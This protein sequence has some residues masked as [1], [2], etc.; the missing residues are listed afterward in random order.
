MPQHEH[1]LRNRRWRRAIALGA[2]FATLGTAALIGPQPSAEATPAACRDDA[3]WILDEPNDPGSEGDRLDVAPAAPTLDVVTY[4][5][6]SGLGSRHAF[7]RRRATVERNLRAI[8]QSIAAAAD[9]ARGPDVVALNEVD[10]GSRRSGWIDQA[11]FVADELEAHT[12]TAYHVVRGETWR[13][14]VPGLEVRFGNAA[15][16]RL[17]LIHATTCQFDELERCELAVPAITPLRRRSGGVLTRFLREP[18]GVIR[19]TVELEGQP[20][21]VLVTHLDAFDMAARETQAAVLLYQL[22]APDRTTVV[23][24]DMNAVP[25][26]L[27]RGRWMFSTDR[28][29][30]ILATGGLADASISLASRRRQ[31]SLAAWATYPSSQPAWGLDWV[32]G[33]PD[34]APD[35]VAAIG[36]S[37][38][39]HRG[40]HVRYRRLHDAAEIEAA[41]IRHGRI[42]ARLRAYD[43]ACGSRGS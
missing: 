8:A 23:A 19:V 3:P 36:D 7:L 37:A 35:V 20:V 22:L 10:F 4:N 32:L 6:H 43:A 40:L 27:T 14:D 5:L 39:D 11:R 21:D 26:V 33:S 1:R 13:R 16:V 15:L 34:L 17:P 2:V 41:R 38:S 24:G 25:G 9:T 42:C 18:R 28:T 29:H 12:G 31:K 30:A